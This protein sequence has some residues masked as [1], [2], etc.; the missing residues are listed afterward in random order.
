MNLRPVLTATLACSLVLSPLAYG[1]A[2]AADRGNWRASSGT[3]RSI[4]GDIGFSGSKIY[5]NFTPFTVAQLVTISFAQATAAFGTSAGSEGSGNIYALNI[6]ASKKFIGKNTLCGT[7]AV[8]YAVTW[9]SGKDL[10]LAFFSGP[11]MPMLTGETLANTTN[12][13][14]TYSYVR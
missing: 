7:D 11:S 13:C 5:L 12:L 6:P 8:T 1:Q 4:T 3:A 14:G 9:V 2:A 10:Q